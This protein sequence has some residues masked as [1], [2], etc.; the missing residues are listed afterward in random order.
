VWCVIGR[1]AVWRDVGV[2]PWAGV[3]G[4]WGE[5]SGDGSWLVGGR[6]GAGRVGGMLSVGAG[7]SIGGL[8]QFGR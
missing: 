1:G 6:P 2:G 5:A 7:F 3:F 8:D 4:E